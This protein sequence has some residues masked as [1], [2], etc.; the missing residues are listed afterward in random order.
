MRELSRANLEELE[1]ISSELASKA[2]FVS[3]LILRVQEFLR[4]LEF[5]TAD[6]IEID[7]NGRAGIGFNRVGGDWSLAYCPFLSTTNRSWSRLDSETI[8][9][10]VGAVPFLGPLIEKILASQ[11]SVMESV[12][13]TW[14][15]ALA[16]HKQLAVLE[17]GAK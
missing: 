10:K 8:L 6:E 7:D 2:T 12:N 4:S 14:D 17:K 15:S 13:S 3:N 16:L 1:E 5:K 11:T 9:V